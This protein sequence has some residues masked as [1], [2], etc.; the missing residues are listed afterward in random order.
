MPL[1][2]EEFEQRKIEVKKFVASMRKA[3]INL[4]ELDFY[5]YF[6]N[7]VGEEYKEYV[8]IMALSYKDTI[9]MLYPV[10]IYGPYLPDYINHILEIA[11]D[12]ADDFL[13]EA[14][15]RVRF[16]P[17][18]EIL[19]KQFY[20]FKEILKHELIHY[21]NAHLPRTIEFF[22]KKGFTAIPPQL[23]DLA[24]IYADSLCN[25]YL[26]KKLVEKGGLV[27]PATENVTLEELLERIPIKNVPKDSEIGESQSDQQSG[28]SGEGSQQDTEKEGK[29]KGGQRGQQGQKG[30]EKREQ[31][32]GGGGGSQEGEEKK[33]QQ[34]GAGGKGGK[35][36]P[37]KKEWQLGDGES[38]GFKDFTPQDVDEL[39][40]HDLD[41]IKD[42]LRGILER[43]LNEY[44]ESG[45]GREIPGEFEEAIKWL[46]K[47]TPKK[48]LVTD[49]D[50]FGL[51]KE[52][53]RTFMSPHPA[54]EMLESEGI[55][56]PRLEP[57]TGGIVVVVIDTSG[58]M[59]STK[60][61]YGLDLLNEIVSSYE[62][63]LVEID[64][65]IQR[66][67]KIDSLDEDMFTFAG[68]GDTSFAD[69]ERLP[70]YISGSDEVISCILFTDGHVSE[71]PEKNPFPNAT[72]IG[73][74]TDVIPEESPDWIRWHKIEEVMEDVDQDE[75]GNDY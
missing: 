44:R 11:P 74:A 59:D 35:E 70:E 36:A 54:S 50:E 34:E 55:F 15:K 66:V 5:T 43:K 37:Y 4:G 47:K 22:K 24:N 21:A 46:R 13:R 40:Q 58:S 49:A 41:S 45:E 32:G 60:L 17:E 14:R 65:A 26:D 16:G 9:H 7:T 28:G 18:S 42:V 8:P 20:V 57:L 61:S 31:Q 30:E 75:G 48:K 29:G 12:I 3:V 68:R 56:L 52:L 51:L 72:W 10:I 6:F 25:I 62:T 67:R 64:V 23:M 27:P 53:E 2:K 38:N 39:S 19:F 1:S 63:Y 33:E 69:L 73:I 71:F